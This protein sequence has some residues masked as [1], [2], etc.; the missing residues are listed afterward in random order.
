VSSLPPQVGSLKKDDR[1]TAR[2]R[3]GS[4]F[5]TIPVSAT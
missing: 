2:H 3:A 1:R 5:S 4:Q